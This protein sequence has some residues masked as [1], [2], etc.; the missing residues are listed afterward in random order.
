MC[1]VSRACNI[2]PLAFILNRYREH[3][4]TRK[5]QFIMWFS[6]LRGAIAFALSLN[7]ELN[8]EVRHVIITTTLMLVLFTTMVLGGGTM[9]LM[10]FLNR[11]SERQKTSNSGQFVFFS[12]T[13]EMGDHIEMMGKIE[14]E[15]NEQFLGDDSDIQFVSKR[16]RLKGFARIDEKVLKPFFIRKFT[17]EVISYLP[18]ISSYKNTSRIF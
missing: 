17:D 16:V 18:P 14:E 7:L 8:T 11:I 5:M 9:P 6:G 10:K 12:K 15:T 1:L 3:K 13:K 2:F 4:I